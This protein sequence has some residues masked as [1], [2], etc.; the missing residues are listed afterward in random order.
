[1]ICE[2]GARGLGVDVP[3][4]GETLSPVLGRKILREVEDWDRVCMPAQKPMYVG[5][6]YSFPSPSPVS[7]D[8]RETS[9]NSS[10]G[11]YQSNI[12]RH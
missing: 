1:M 8:F 7:S 2:Q 10:F 3:T 11:K 6:E 9:F 12:E 5:Y 4:G